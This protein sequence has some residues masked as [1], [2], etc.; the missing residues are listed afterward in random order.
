MKFHWGHGISLAIVG[1]VGFMGYLAYRAFQ[2]PSNLV[3]EDYYEAGLQV[4][5]VEQSLREGR[6]LEPVTISWGSNEIQFVNLADQIDPGSIL[7]LENYCP[8]DPRG[9]WEV[10]F[11]WPKGEMPHSEDI[12][13]P[14]QFA[15]AQ[16]CKLEAIWKFR[17]TTRR[18]RLEASRQ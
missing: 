12:A 9:D 3:R 6:R 16:G 7:I 11:I 15:L 17:D 18:Q 1:F 8:N 5:S 14:V 10:R 2:I 4:D 13:F